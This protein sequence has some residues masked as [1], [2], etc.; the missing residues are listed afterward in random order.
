VARRGAL[1]IAL[2]SPALALLGT[3]PRAGAGGTITLSAGAGSAGSRITMT[4]TGFDP[5]EQVQ[6]NWD[7]N[8]P[9]AVAMK[10]F[11]NWNPIVVADSTGTARTD[12]FV[13]V[14]IG[15]SHT[16][17]LVGLTSGVV[18][19]TA[20]QVVPRLDTGSHIA[21][22][23]TTLSFTGWDL[24]YRESVLIKWNGTQINKASTD[25]KGSIS[26]KTYQIP[27]GTPAGS[28]AVTAT[29]STSGLIASATVTVG[30]VPTGPAPGADDWP[31]W[32]FDQQQHRV[33]AVDTGF[34]S[35]NIAQVGLAWQQQVPGPDI[36]QASPVVANGIVYAGS[37]HGL[38]SAYDA[39]TGTPIWSFQAPGPIYASPTIANGIAYF[40]TVNEPQETIV[41]NY[42]FALNATTG[43]VIWADPLPNGGEWAAPLIADGVAYFTMANREAVSGGVIAFDALTGVKKWQTD[44]PYGIWAQPSLDPSGQFLYQ[45]TGNPCFTEPNPTPGDGCSGYVLKFNVADGTFTQLIHVPDF[46]GDDDVATAPTYDNGNLLFGAKDGLF[47]SISAA[48][49]AVNWPPVDTGASGDGGIYSS[50]ATYNGVIFFGSMGTSSVWAVNEATGAVLW[51][52]TLNGPVAASPIVADGMVFA[53]SFGKSS[54]FEALDP[55]TGAVLWSTSLAAPSGGSAAVANGMI[56]QTAGNGT[57]NAYK[58][59]SQAPAFVS[60]SSLTAY[61]GNKVA[62][63]VTAT[64]LPGPAIS[65]TGTLPTGV[66]FTAG[67][68]GGSATFSGTPAAGQQ[69]V[70]PLTLTAT[71]ASG[72][73]TQN[74]TLTVLGVAPAFTSPTSGTTKVGQPFSAAV[75]ATGTPAPVLFASTGTVPPGLTFVD[76]GVG[77]GTLSGTP[78]AAGTFTVVI[79][80]TNGVTPNAVL[81]YTLTVDANG[82][83]PVF[84]A[85]TPPTSVAVGSPYSYTF[86]ATGA[87]AYSVVNGTLPPGLTLDSASGNLSGTPTTAGSYTFQVQAS[88][89]GSPALTP[90]IT[91]TVLGPADM[92]VGISG[93]GGKVAH[94]STMNFTVTANNLGT[95]TASGITASF[96]L[97]AGTS[98]VSA[99]SGGTYANGVVTWTVAPLASGKHSNLVV[100]ITAASAGSY[101]VSANAQAAN[102]DPNPANNSANFTV[103]V[104]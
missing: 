20:F 84:T 34:T 3:P 18:D 83:A 15:G 95:A 37:I 72:T 55:A 79:N 9:N 1:V 29:G 75:T 22:A 80:A 100:S 78:T 82:L 101:T 10:S 60:G 38:L 96:T 51:Q 14:V 85:D 19:S 36:Y 13:P 31:Q 35:S 24:G 52:R 28:Y 61:V 93:P 88:G 64:G 21:P 94:G 16:I 65:E 50:G 44:R 66:K 47:Y 42:A 59:G 81:D 48:T 77:N 11:Y 30:A 40:G 26:G 12:L 57:L 91:I 17:S 74:F 33:N 92:S 46:S 5:G 8:T 23:G 67:T 6:P 103:T 69:G 2:L 98:F 63:T 62:M 32:G 89:S 90:S 97:P 53:A 71:N 43:A 102:P 54:N 45:G 27:S 7:I 73:T 99:L 41:G 4:G 68:Y 87:T 58:L 49:G 25:S 76:N 86:A 104:T 56:Y 70:Y 39:V